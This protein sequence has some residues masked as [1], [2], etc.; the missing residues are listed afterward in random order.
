M[1]LEKLYLVQLVEW[2]IKMLMKAKYESLFTITTVKLDLDFQN[3]K[4]LNQKE[5][6]DLIQLVKII[7]NEIEKDKENTMNT[8]KKKKIIR[9]G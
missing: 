7:I 8:K 6:Q 9:I 1:H 4:K 3:E 2:K 5:F